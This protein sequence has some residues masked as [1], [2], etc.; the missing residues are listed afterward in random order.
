[1]SCTVV[2]TTATHPDAL[3]IPSSAVRSNSATQQKYVLVG[4]TTTG[5]ITQIDVKTG[6]VVGTQTEILS[7]LTAG[8]TVLIG[9]SGSTS[10]TASSGTAGP[11]GGGGVGFLFGGRG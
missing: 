4:D 5:A 2:I 8:Q 6:I 9:G 10:S 7:G 3:V 11:R 1:M